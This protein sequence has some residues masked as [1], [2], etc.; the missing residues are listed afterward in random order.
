MA[1]ATCIHRSVVAFIAG[2][3]VKRDYRL[4][5]IERRRFI[6]RAQQSHASRW[7]DAGW[8]FIVPNASE[9]F[10][11]SRSEAKKRIISRIVRKCVSTKITHSPLSPYLLVMKYAADI[12]Y[13]K[14][15]E[16]I[17]L[18][19]AFDAGRIS[20][21]EF[22]RRARS[23]PTEQLVVLSEILSAPRGLVRAAAGGSDSRRPA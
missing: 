12:D 1:T 2:F 15:T 21:T 10:Q 17:D 22:Q 6:D 23:M 18:V 4:H 16:L 19:A 13:N 7:S 8:L 5:A 9:L 3:E 20:R 14:F 11:R